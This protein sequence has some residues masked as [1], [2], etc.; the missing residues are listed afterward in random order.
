MKTLVY[1][2]EIIT[3]QELWQEIEFATNYIRN[4]LNMFLKIRRKVCDRIQKFTKVDGGHFENLLNSF[5][6][7]VV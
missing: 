7:T 1:P 5:I 3:R 4:Q 2:S 6:A